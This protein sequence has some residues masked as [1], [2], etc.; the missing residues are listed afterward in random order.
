MLSHFEKGRQV[1]FSRHMS[2]L[3]KNPLCFDAHHVDVGN[4]H[5]LFSSRD[6][7]VWGSISEMLCKI[8]YD[9]LFIEGQ[10]ENIWCILMKTH[11]WW[12]IISISC[13]IA[14]ICLAI[15]HYSQLSKSRRTSLK[16]SFILLG[17]FDFTFWTNIFF[18]SK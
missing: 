8:E 5:R 12:R 7:G 2:I 1:L 15:C 9:S 3:T 6:N 11:F 13:K 18:S 17:W 10:N 4:I 14:I 16:P